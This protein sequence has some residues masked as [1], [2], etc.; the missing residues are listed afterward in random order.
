MIQTQRLEDSMQEDSPDVGS[1]YPYANP[2]TE[3]QVTDFIMGTYHKSKELAVEPKI[4]TKKYT[5]RVGW[6]NLSQ[7]EPI[8]TVNQNKPPTQSGFAYPMFPY[9][10]GGSFVPPR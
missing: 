10:K 7:T 1:T 9:V 8:V 4:N 2:E 6:A 5:D 3:S